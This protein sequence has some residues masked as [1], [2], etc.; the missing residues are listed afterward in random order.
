MTSMISLTRTNLLGVLLAVPR[1][2]PV[3]VRTGIVAATLGAPPLAVGLGATG[4][5]TTVIG[6]FTPLNIIC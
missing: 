6:E 1:T 5:C 2:T 3:G 4:L